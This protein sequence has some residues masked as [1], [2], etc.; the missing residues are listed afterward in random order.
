MKTSLLTL[1]LK[2][3]LI[4]CLNDALMMENTNRSVGISYNFSY[5]WLKPSSQCHKSVKYD[6]PGDCSSEN[7]CL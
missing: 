2:Q 7:D 1:D 6:C 5:K 4:G 3:L